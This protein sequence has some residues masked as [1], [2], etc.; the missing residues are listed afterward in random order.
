MRW[1][2]GQAALLAKELRKNVPCPVC[3]SKE[4]PAPAFDKQKLVDKAELDEVRSAESNSRK[5]MDKRKKEW[6]VKMAR[7]PTLSHVEDL[8]ENIQITVPI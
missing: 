6:D 5:V 4:H 1:H 3:G 8:M 2:A 7:C